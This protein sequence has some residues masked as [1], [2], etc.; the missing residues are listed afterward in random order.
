[1]DQA[2]AALAHFLLDRGTRVHL[3]ANDVE[4]E[5]VS[6]LGAS[7]NLAA[8][9]AGSYFLGYA[10]IRRLARRVADE[11]KRQFPAAR[12]VANGGCYP[13]AEINWVHYIDKAWSR[14]NRGAPSWYRAKTLVDDLVTRRA[15]RQ[16]M[17]TA[18]LYIVNSRST[19]DGLIRL[20]GVPRESIRVVY[21]SCD[22]SMSPPTLDDRAKACAAIGISGAAPTIAFVGALG[23]DNRKG[24]DTLVDAWRRLS[25]NQKWDCNLVVAGGGRGLDAW[26]ARIACEGLSARIRMLGATDKVAEVL[27]ASDLIVSPVRYE[28]YGLNVHEAICSGVPAMVSRCAGVAERYPAQLDAMLIDDPEDAGA[29][30]EKMLA[31]R[32]R[33]EDWQA[34]FAPLGVEFRARS[35]RDVARDF[36]DVVE[37][38][39]G[40]SSCAEKPNR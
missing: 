38:A 32:A 1:M 13:R 18:R 30:A 9:P 5:L 33:V 20:Y 39:D 27:A 3:V 40:P 7:V 28:P 37:Q 12:V 19:R 6:A 24:F 34:A 8:R 16:A 4:P 14:A 2:N 22:A 29:L 25:D 36:V 35:W 11:V 21:L 26:R 31:W 15:E 17:R 10:M 23:F